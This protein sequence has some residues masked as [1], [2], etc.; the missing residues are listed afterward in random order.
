[1]LYFI[2]FLLL[3]ASCSDSKESNSPSSRGE[4][5]TRKHDEFAYRTL[6]PHLQQRESYPWEKPLIGNHPPITK[7]HF[8][9]KGSSLNPARLYHNGKE[10]IKLFDCGGAEKHSLPLRNGNEFIYPILIKL[11]NYIQAQTSKKIVITCGHRCP[12]HNAYSDPSKDNLY[13][14]HM[15]GAEVSFYVQGLENQPEKI[16]SLI[17]KFYQERYKN[18]EYT[19]F[20]RYSKPDTNTSIHPWYNKEVYVKVFNQQEGRNMDNRHPYPYL[21]IQV[22]YDSDLNSRVIY[23]WNQAYKNYLRK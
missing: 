21:S 5:I 22:R 20:K 13:S 14:K 19:S 23:D 18:D 6:Q 1:M 11:M 15:I 4:F 2:P 17:Q 7:E 16:V 10:S 12:D 8:R 3:L 9:C